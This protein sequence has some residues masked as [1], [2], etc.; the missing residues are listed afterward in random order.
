MSATEELTIL[1]P[2]GLLAKLHSASV[3]RGVPM[4]DMIVTALQRLADEGYKGHF[5]RPNGGR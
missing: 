5:E 1:L 4:G 3:R 2:P